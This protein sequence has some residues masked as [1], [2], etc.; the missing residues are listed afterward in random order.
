MWNMPQQAHFGQ[1]SG[2]EAESFRPR[3]MDSGCQIYGT[4]GLTAGTGRYLIPERCVTISA[5]D[6]ICFNVP[7]SQEPDY[8]I[9][10]IYPYRFLTL[11]VEKL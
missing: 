1:R 8:R 3:G 11:E 10:A 9:V 7:G 5:D 6:G 4:F 2:R